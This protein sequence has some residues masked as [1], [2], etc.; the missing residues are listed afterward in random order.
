MF[1]GGGPGSAIRSFWE[2]LANLGQQGK[3]VKPGYEHHCVCLAWIRLSGES[4][5]SCQNLLDP[6]SERPLTGVS[7][8]RLFACF[9]L[10]TCAC[11]KPSGPPPAPQGPSR[12]IADELVFQLSQLETAGRPAYHVFVEA[13]R[14]ETSGRPASHFFVEPGR[15]KTTKRLS[16]RLFVVLSESLALLL[17][18]DAEGREPYPPPW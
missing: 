5:C 18:G 17:I 6:G 14:S 12:A 11:H 3:Q 9:C 4:C 10:A 8:A 13:E 7:I 15:P 2:W 16:Y 1:L